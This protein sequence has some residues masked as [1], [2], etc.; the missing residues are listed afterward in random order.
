MKG[1]DP[2][3]MLTTVY[4]HS[5]LYIYIYI[6]IGLIVYIQVFCYICPLCL[7]MY[8]ISKLLR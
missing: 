7:Q 2:L 1:F 3:Q 4:I 5:S 8:Q 6:Y